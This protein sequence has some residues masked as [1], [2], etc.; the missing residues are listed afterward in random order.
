M[1]AIVC[2]QLSIFRPGVQ[3]G[4]SLDGAY[5]VGLCTPKLQSFDS[6][7][8][9]EK[10][11]LHKLD[12]VFLLAVVKPLPYVSFWSSRWKA[13]QL[14]VCVCVCERA[15]AYFGE[16]LLYVPYVSRMS[17]KVTVRQPAPCVG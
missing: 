9:A 3:S 12:S 2:V 14:Q 8:L 16:C 13:A 7:W 6:E 5:A 10:E 11:G 17:A 15:R 1:R 4:E